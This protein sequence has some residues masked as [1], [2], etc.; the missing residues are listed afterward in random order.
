MDTAVADST[1]VKEEEIM[2]VV[3]GEIPGE[4][5]EEPAEHHE[6]T[7][8]NEGNN[9]DDPKRNGD[10]VVL[11]DKFVMAAMTDPV[12][13]RRLVAALD[14]KQQRLL[15]TIVTTSPTASLLIGSSG[16]DW[17]AQD[18]VMRCHHCRIFIPK[19]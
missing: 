9:C 10:T 16:D 2:T 6:E 11:L 15:N 3:D 8:S 5:N 18:E 17:I 13:V 14:N 19:K 7:S 12:R 1:A 4:N